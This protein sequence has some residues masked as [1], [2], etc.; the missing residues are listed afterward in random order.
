VGATVLQSLFHGF[1]DLLYP[2]SCALCTVRLVPF[3]S[4]LCDSCRLNVLPTPEW[5]CRLCGA[6]GR[7]PS[8]DRGPCRYCPPPGAAWRGVL[9]ATDYGPEAAR[10]VHLFKYDRRL[11]IGTMMG[12]MMVARLAEPLRVLGD[13]IAWVVPVPLHWGRRAGRGF[14]QADL[15]GRALADATGLEFV[16]G[17]L[18]RV[19]ATRRQV[20][21][22]VHRRAENVRGAFR[23]ARRPVSGLPGVL[24]VDDIVTS[25]HTVAEC[26]RVLRAAGSP[27]VWIACFARAGTT[28][29]APSGDPD[30]SEVRGQRL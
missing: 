14:N 12:R 16:P 13:R 29:A 15:L 25:G 6:T 7:G 21:V 9:A 11:E 20:R 8:P 2:P 28:E 18:R 24:L 4:E 23:V 19:R 30:G 22:P 10:C 26:A 3:E 1:V 27:E 17:A 5:R